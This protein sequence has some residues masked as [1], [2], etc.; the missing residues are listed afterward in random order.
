MH[1]DAFAQAFCMDFGRQLLL[2]PLPHEDSLRSEPHIIS[3]TMTRACNSVL[4]HGL[5]VLNFYPDQHDFVLPKT[6][7]RLQPQTIHR[8]GIVCLPGFT[9]CM[10][11]MMGNYSMHGL[12]GNFLAYRPPNRFDHFIGLSRGVADPVIIK[13]NVDISHGLGCLWLKFRL[14]RCLM[15]PC[16]W[17]CLD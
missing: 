14:S 3:L 12:S 10:T 5:K 4:C 15:L 16:W 17:M 1:V 9:P 2:H 6:S 13:N 7:Q 8:I 11:W